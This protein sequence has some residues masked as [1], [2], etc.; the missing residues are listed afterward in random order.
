MASTV[1]R[2]AQIK[3]STVQRHDLDTSTVGQAVVTKIVQGSGVTL[4]S[5]GADSGTGDVTVAASAIPLASSAQS[6]LLNQTSGNTTDFIDGTNNSQALQPVIWSVRLRSFNSLGNSN[7]EVDQRNVGNAV[8]NPAGGTMII[9][10]WMKAGTGTYQVSCQQIPSGAGVVLPGTNFR[11]SAQTFRILLTTPQATLGASDRLGLRTQIE[12]PR[13]R[14][15]MNDVHSVSLL[16]NSSVA[17]LSFSLALYAPTITTASLVKLCTIP[18]A[19]TWTLIQLP[20]IPVWSAAGNWSILP[21]VQ[22]YN[23]EICLAAGATMIAPAADVWQNAFYTGAPGMSN[24]C[25][26]AVN[27]T[28]WAAFIQHEPGPCTTLQDLPFQQNLDDCLRYYT[29][30]YHYNT[31]AGTASSGAGS[32][33]FPAFAGNQPYCWQ[34]FKKVMAK[35]P[36]VTSYSPTTG[37][38]NTM[39]DVTPGN[40]DRAVTAAVNVGDTGFSGFNITGAN[41]ANWIAQFNW[42]ADTGW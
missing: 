31:I 1:I 6:G 28:F 39:R 29:K 10:R 26:Q 8:A 37:A 5:T 23:L 2:G 22:G 9:D 3:D 34:P 24:F 35:I 11:V 21:T 40:V 30:S 42:T 15:L 36:T 38:I 41:A 13:M 16:V 32:A 17:P 25:G 27:S 7:F 14:E 12:G 20:N 4:S 33:I 18:T 19:S